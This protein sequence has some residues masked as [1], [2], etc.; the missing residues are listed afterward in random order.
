MQANGLRFAYLE[1]GSGPLVLL[2][3]GFPDTAHT[4]T[5]VMP[6]IAEAGFR[7][8]APFTRGYAPTEIPKDGSFDTETLAKDVLGLI[9]ALG[10]GKPAVIVGHDWGASA[11]YSA[12]AIAPEKVKLLVTMAI[13]HPGGITPTPKLVWTLRHFFTLRTRNAAAKLAANNFAYVDELWHRWSPAWKSIPASETEHV[14]QAFSD[15]AC[16]AAACL[17]Y[18][19]S[20]TKTPPSQ[21]IQIA[22]PTVSFAGT[23]DMIAPRVYEKVRHKFTRSYEVVQVPGGHFMHREHPEAFRTELVRVLR[24]KATS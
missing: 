7:A 12:A 13:P 21:K 11:G 16:A 3:H 15:P 22:V 8:V 24:D 2:V 19:H 1:Q 6:A 17:Y 18:R 14:K 4:W 23:H 20:G 5:D 10:D 9:D